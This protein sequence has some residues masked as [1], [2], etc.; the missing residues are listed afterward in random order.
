MAVFGVVA[1]SSHLSEANATGMMPAAARSVR[2]P[3]VLPRS[4]SDPLVLPSDLYYIVK[5]SHTCRGF[6]APASKV[7]S[8]KGLVGG[9]VRSGPALALLPPPLTHYAHSQVHDRSSRLFAQLQTTSKGRTLVLEG[10]GTETLLE[11]MHSPSQRARINVTLVLGLF[12]LVH[13]IETANV[14]TAAVGLRNYSSCN[15]LTCPM[16]RSLLGHRRCCSWL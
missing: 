14:R 13:P 3:Y 9:S 5:V 4:P 12:A 1:S 6:F 15:V 10:G 16:Q 7:H 11:L 2:P 8:A